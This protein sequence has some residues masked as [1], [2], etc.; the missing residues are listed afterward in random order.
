MK[1]PRIAAQLYTIRD[2]TKTPDDLDR[3]MKRIKEIG[4]NRYR[5][6]NRADGTSTSKRYYG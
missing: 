1:K 3:S 4:Y 5:Y 2:F 6:G